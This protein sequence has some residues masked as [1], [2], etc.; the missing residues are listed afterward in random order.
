MLA[1]CPTQ[2]VPLMPGASSSPVPL[3]GFSLQSESMGLVNQHKPLHTSITHMYYQICFMLSAQIYAHLHFLGT[4]RL[5]P[6][7]FVKVL[8]TY[9]V[10]TV[11]MQLV[12]ITIAYL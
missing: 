6:T 8:C 9:C 2:P 1:P 11:N 5:T 10:R 12:V 4:T 3:M 7:I